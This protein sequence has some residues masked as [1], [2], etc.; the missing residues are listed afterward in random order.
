[1]RKSFPLGVV[2]ALIVSL[3][4]F[5]CAR[6]APTATPTR[7]PAVTPTP[8][9]VPTPTTRP[10]PRGTLN[11]S[12]ANLG[13]EVWLVRMPTSDEAPI[14]DAVFD[15]LIGFDTKTQA[16]PQ[17]GGSHPGL[18]AK[19]SVELTPDG[20]SLWKMT[21]RKGVQFHQ[22]WG[23]LTAEDVKFTVNEFFKPQSVHPYTFG[24]VAWVGKDINNFKIVDNYSF[25]VKSNEQNFLQVRRLSMA[26]LGLSPIS[27]K[28]QEAVGEDA[29]GKRP[30]GTGSFELVD[31]KRNQKV[32]L[33]AVNN[34]WRQTP[35]VAEVNITVVPEIATNIAMLRTGQVDLTSI[36]AKY[37]KEL[38]AAG[39]NIFRGEMAKAFNMFFGG[40]FLPTREKYNPASP[41][42]GKEPTGE[43]PTLVRKALNLAIDR[44]AIMDK[45]LFNEAV[46]KVISFNFQKP[47]VYWWKNDWKPYPYDAKGAKEAITK[48]GYPNGFDTQMYL[49][50]LAWAPENVDMSEAIASMWEQNLGLKVKRQPTEYRPTVR[51]KL[52]ERSSADW[53][54]LYTN[55]S[56]SDPVNYGCGCCIGPSWAT[57]LHTEHPKVDEICGPLLKEFDLQ[58]QVPLIQALG[59]FLYQN[60]WTAPI[61]SG[62][63]LWAAGPKVKDYPVFPGA[64]TLKN[65]ELI[66]LK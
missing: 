62:N 11:V 26:G 38:E 19:W 21:L 4:L 65:L 1:M 30:V 35:D 17:T 12:V 48:A 18:A 29:V 27:K 53:T 23:E 54:Y 9:T 7:A 22:G 3:V 58:K 51:Q 40:M 63:V 39:L 42:T 24:Y 31:H 37:K 44:Q 41:W 36:P 52:V 66:T 43:S 47:G 28:Y 59:D 55:A 60:Y 6:A 50:S 46:P 45:I 64:S 61:A 33:K 15:A 57:I 56:I 32:S 8:T 14:M 10:G 2:F 25:E 5:A 34:H 13:N 16:F 49:I 20:G